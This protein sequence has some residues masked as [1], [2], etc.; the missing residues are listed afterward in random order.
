MAKKHLTLFLKY[1]Q[2][3]S[4]YKSFA[5]KLWF[6][7]SMISLGLIPYHSNVLIALEAHVYETGKLSKIYSSSVGYDFWLHLFL[8]PYLFTEHNEKYGRMALRHYLLDEILRNAKKDKI[9]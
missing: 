9:L 5:N 4:N 7:G 2:L 1:T 6:A 8:T 3:S